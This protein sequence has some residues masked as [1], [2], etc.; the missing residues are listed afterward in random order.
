MARLIDNP[1]GMW[2]GSARKIEPSEEDATDLLAGF[3]PTQVLNLF[4]LRSAIAHGRY[5]ETTLEHARLV[6][7]RW[8]VQHGRVS[9]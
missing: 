4:R 2:K 5:S 3:T 7:A 9:D 8:L 6:F 1:F